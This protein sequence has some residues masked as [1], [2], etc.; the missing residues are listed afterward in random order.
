MK[1]AV[2]KS[3]LLV[4]LAPAA[5]AAQTIPSQAIVSISPQQCVWRAGDNPAWAAPNLDETGWQPYAHWKANPGELQIWIRCRADV[6][7]FDGSN[8]SA[9][10]VGLYAAYQ[11][12]LDGGLLGGSGNLRNGNFSLSSTR[13]FPVPTRSL[14]PGPIS[15]ALRVTR[16][17]AL[18]IG[19]PVPVLVTQPLELRFGDADLLD[20]LR[21]RT[22]LQRTSSYADTAACYGVIGVV[23]IMLL[24][25]FLY[26]SSRRELLLLCIACLSVAILRLNEFCTI[27]QLNYSLDACTL[28]VSVANLAFTVTQVPFFFA[29]ARRRIP[30]LIWI[31]LVVALLAHGYAGIDAVLGLHGPTLL[32]QLNVPLVLAVALPAHVVLSLASFIAFW[33]FSRIAPRMRPV[34]ALCLLW[35]TADLA[36]FIV[37][38]T[39][40]IPIPNMQS[41]FGHWQLS[42]LEARAFTTAGVLAAL[43]ALLFREQRQVTQDRAML[44]GEMRAAR[45]VQQVII[46]EAI[47]TVPG[48]AIESIYKPAGEVGGDFFQ[49]LPTPAGGVLIVIGDVSGKG[50]PAAM[51]VSLLVGTVRTLAHYTHSPGEI[52]AAMNTRMLGRSQG[53][54]TTCLVLE[55]GADG[56]LKVA[57]AGHLAPYLNGAELALEFGLPLGLDPHSTY[58]ESE[59]Q[60]PPG[61]KLT[62]LSDGVV[63][64]RSS[65]GELFGFERTAALSTDSA[66]NIARAAQHFGQEDD[67][68]VLTL[69]LAPAPIPAPIGPFHA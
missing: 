62:V 50:M 43:L 56:K 15:L 31:A 38:G 11:L 5:F 61:A 37:Q 32:K 47:P 2:P 8:P 40:L 54:F 55:A 46:P 21:A 57:N 49:I 58:P 16:H 64:A 68:T 4:L 67:I 10:Q 60:L 53:G 18:A 30:L 36:W 63:E 35:G 6:A 39:Q 14:G 41:L 12:Y 59:F 20:A 34:A 28:I 48:F 23:A 27:S 33:P 24:G 65:S 17:R 66:Q 22:I 3:L 52:L 19:G 9:V 25:L 26:D 69:T 29:L 13:S 51:T 1:V 45:A 42:L 7:A 44:A